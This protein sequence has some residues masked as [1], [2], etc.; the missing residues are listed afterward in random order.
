MPAALLLID[1]QHDYL[2]RP[3]LLP[4]AATVVERAATLLHGFRQ[5]N[6][7]VAHVHTRVRRDGA[8]RMPHWVR[9]DHWAC[10]EGT[11]GVEPPPE[12]APREPE[13]VFTK[14]FYSAWAS[15]GLA[16]HLREQSVNTVV[17]AGLYT[18]ACVR[19]TVLDAYQAGFDVWLAT[20]AVGSYDP[21]HAELSRAHLEARACRSLAVDQILANLGAPPASST[22]VTDATVPVAHVNGAWVAAREQRTVARHDPCDGSICQAVVPLGTPADMTHAVDAAAARQPEWAAHEANARGDVLAQ[23]ADALEQRR[24]ALRAHI[25]AEIGKPRADADAEVNYALALIAAVRRDLERGSVERVAPDVQARYRPLGTLGLITPWNNPL[26]LPVGKIAPALAWGN[27]VVWKAPVEAPHTAMRMMEAVAETPLPPG[28]A[29]LVFG[30]GRTAQGMLHDPRVAGV[31][32]TG[33]NRAGQFVRAACAMHNKPLQ[34]ELGGNNGVVIAPPIDLDAVARDLAISAYSCAGQRCTAPRRV[35]VLP[36]ARERFIQSFAEAV[37]ALRVGAPD[38][39][40]TQVGPLVSRAAQQR[41]A[42][43]VATATAQGA[44]TL[45]GGYVPRGCEAGCWYAPTLVSGLSPNAELVRQ[46]SFGPVVTLLP[47][48]DLDQAMTLLNQ[49][50]HGLVATLY[51]DDQTVQH[52]FLETAQAGILRVNPGHAAIHPEAPFGGWKASAQGPPEHGPYDRWFY[53]RPQAL[54]THTTD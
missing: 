16:E 23:W 34:A 26:A 42:T 35:I 47:A 44:D 39:A 8:N 48:S 12:L 40:A 14:P 41:I 18:H 36:E 9:A 11:P 33:S 5:I 22:A 54:Y 52:R 43:L 53:T 3:G 29:N 37:Q 17:V 15:P 50:E 6:A 25:V 51:A 38:D 19:A 27:T 21:L 13:P 24:D 10:V 4:P 2:Q 30:D 1:L 32:F 45:A 31:S 46:E 49:V 20:D 28:C 7:P